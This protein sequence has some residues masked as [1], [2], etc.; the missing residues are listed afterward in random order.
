MAALIFII[1]CLVG[2]GIVE[3]IKK[4]YEKLGGKAKHYEQASGILLGLTALG[5]YLSKKRGAK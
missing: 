5:A 1:P 3:G 4:L 2:I